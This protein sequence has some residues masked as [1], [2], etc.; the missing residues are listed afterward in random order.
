VATPE[1]QLKKVDIGGLV[2]DVIASKGD[3]N[4][5]LQRKTFEEKVSLLYEFIAREQFVNF[6]DIGANYGFVSMLARK[7]APALNI[8]SVEADPRLARLIDANFH[9]NGLEPPIVINCVAGHLDD[10]TV[11]FS[12][13]P[14]STLDNRVRMPQWTQVQVPMMRIGTLL[15]SHGVSGK[16]F[17]KI[18]T[19]GFELHVLQGLESWLGR[20]DDWLLKMEFAPQW[21]DSQG[22][23]ALE[24]LKYL[25]ARYEF[26]EFLERIP[27]GMPDTEALF[28]YPVQARQMNRFLEYV[29]SLNKNGQGWVDLIVRPHNRARRSSSTA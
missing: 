29:T 8:L 21:L 1:V 19:Q 26:A 28:E 4:W 3:G 20:R 17:F 5:Y 23:D 14:T 13:N 7:A 15:E 16:T 9:A 6:V 22:T 10:Q 18:D 25:D 2:I 12:L 27:F 24:L 11:G